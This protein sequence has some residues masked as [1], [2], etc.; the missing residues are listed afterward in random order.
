MLPPGQA[1]H[2]IRVEKNAEELRKGERYDQ[3]NTQF[4]IEIKKRLI[5]KPK[6]N[7]WRTKELQY[8]N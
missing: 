4:N 7:K 5:R 3:W 8:M 6:E 2:Y 1:F